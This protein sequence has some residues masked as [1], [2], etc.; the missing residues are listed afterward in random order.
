ML[1]RLVI[2]PCGQ[3][4]EFENGKTDVKRIPRLCYWLPIAALGTCAR[5]AAMNFEVTSATPS[6]ADFRLVARDMTAALDY[7]AI[8]PAAAS[9]IIAGADAFASYAP[10]RDSGA[11]QRLTGQ[12]VH[13]IEVGGLRAHA[14]LPLDFDVGGFVGGVLDSRAHVYGGNVRYAV[15][16][17][18]TVTPAVAVRGSFTAA[19]GLQDLSYR[20]YGTDVSVSK[21]FPFVAPYAGFGVVVSRV[22]ADSRYGLDNENAVQA[23][24]FAGLRLSLGP[25]ES[26]FE[27]ERLGANSVYNLRFGVSI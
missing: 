18:S 27:Y 19:A 20:S 15:L 2:L 7:K 24:G 3:H 25:L 8:E 13:G 23:K 22:K 5:V 9:G 16:E 17:G 26:A 14:E 6:Q 1:R 21:G 4:Q 12:D 11:W 10:T